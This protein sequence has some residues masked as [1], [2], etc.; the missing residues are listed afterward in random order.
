MK[1]STIDEKKF[2]KLKRILLTLLTIIVITAASGAIYKLYLDNNKNKSEQL[3]SVPVDAAFLCLP[4]QEVI[5]EVHKWVDD[6]LKEWQSFSKYEYPISQYYGVHISNTDN[7]LYYIDSIESKDDVDGLKDMISSFNEG[8]DSTINELKI[9]EKEG[10][11]PP[12]FIIDK[13]IKQIDGFTPQKVGDNIV[14]RGLIKKVDSMKEINDSEK[15]MIIKDVESQVKKFTYP[16]YN[17]LKKYLYTLRAK[18]DSTPGV[19]KFKGGDEYYK[20]AIKHSTTLAV[21]PEEI[22]DTGIKEVERLKGELQKEFKAIGYNG[23]NPEENIKL[24]NEDKNLLYGNSIEDKEKLLED[25]RKI[26]NDAENKTSILFDSKPLEGLRVETMEDFAIQTG[27]QAYYLP[28]SQSGAS[29][30]TFSVNLDKPTYKYDMKSI[31]YHETIPGHHFQ[32][33]L[34]YE[35]LGEKNS[36]PQYTSIPV[37]IEGWALYGEK[38]ADELKLY[39]DNYSRIGYLRGELLRA[40]RLVIDTGIHYKRWTRD[41][42]IEYMKSVGCIPD[43]YLESEIDRYIVTPGDACSYKIGQLKI[44]ELRDKAKKEL[45]DRFNI[46]EFHNIILRNGPM[47]IPIMEEEVKKYIDAKKK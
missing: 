41:E 32:M 22:Y 1:Q 36:E 3:Y 44:L 7:L 43:E 25:Y 42:A 35:I 31:A 19:W 24:L 47:P 18:A 16:S 46:K 10:I 33:T 8:F 38:L 23:E 6:D 27:P 13:V 20:Y 29:E 14:C 40:A 12:D 30:G 21:T 17:K 11:V 34:H 4:S 39:N 5:D 28:S 45:K 15:K 9:R 37:Y 2:S 26:V